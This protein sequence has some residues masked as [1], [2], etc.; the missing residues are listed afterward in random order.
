MHQRDRACSV[1]RF[2]DLSEVTLFLILLASS[3]LSRGRKI[4]VQLIR[5]GFGQMVAS[6]SVLTLNMT[7]GVV[8]DLVGRAV[9]FCLSACIESD[10]AAGTICALLASV[11]PFAFSSA[12]AERS[13]P[14]GPP[15]RPCRECCRR[16]QDSCYALARSIDTA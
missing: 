13:S 11:E 2:Q 3:G 9:E 14:P 5:L 16:F 1:S 15:S 6:R 12:A 7:L 10:T 4:I 8:K